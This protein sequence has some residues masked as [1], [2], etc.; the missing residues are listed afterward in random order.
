MVWMRV[1]QYPPMTSGMKNHVRVRKRWYV[2]NRVMTVKRM[3]KR[4]AA[5]M[6]GLYWYAVQPL[7]ED[8]VIVLGAGV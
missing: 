2:C 6:E 4:T 7:W 5:P 8:M 1:V 3:T